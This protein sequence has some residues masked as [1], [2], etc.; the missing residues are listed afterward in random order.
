[1]NLTNLYTLEGLTC[2]NRLYNPIGL[3][4]YLAS[5]RE[6]CDLHVVLYYYLYY[7]YDGY[8]DMELV[9]IDVNQLI[10]NQLNLHI[11]NRYVFIVFH[12]YRKKIIQISQFER[13]SLIGL[14]IN[15]IKKISYFFNFLFDI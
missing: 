9:S 14:M 12:L 10:D 15:V 11:I 3:V 1:M 13:I 4:S 7:L 2:R 6:Y 8:K 5:Q